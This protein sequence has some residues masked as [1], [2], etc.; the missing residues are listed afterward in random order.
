MKAPGTRHAAAEKA[1]GI[2]SAKVKVTKVIEDAE[3]TKES[4]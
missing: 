3:E 4:K 2:E 1:G